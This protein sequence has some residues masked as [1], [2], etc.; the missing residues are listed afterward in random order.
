MKRIEFIGGPAVGKTTVFNEIT[1]IKKLKDQWMTYKEARIHLAKKVNIKNHTT[2]K[3]AQTILK[4]RAF[5]KVHSKFASFILNKFNE[6]IFDEISNNYEDVSMVFLEELYNNGS[7]SS[8][9]KMRLTSY[10]YNLLLN[11]VIIFDYF[12]LDKLVIYEEG[13]I[14]NSSAFRDDKKASIVLKNHKNLGTSAIP[15]GIVHCYMDEEEYF[16]RRK[17]RI[18]QGKGIFLDRTLSDNDLKELCQR[19]LKSAKEKIEVLKNYNV[20]VLELDMEN[21]I[22]DNARKAHDFINAFQ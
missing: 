1:K 5:E 10:Y 2:I 19:S 12:K 18:S 4:M 3:F 16:K 7:I 22:K 8:I 9:Q 15:I 14:H 17:D 6:N 13:I 11:G 21:P 20:Q